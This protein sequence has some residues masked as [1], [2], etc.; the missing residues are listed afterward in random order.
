MDSV[1]GRGSAQRSTTPLQAC[2]GQHL[3]AAPKS[4]VHRS[5]RIAAGMPNYDRLPLGHLLKLWD[6]AAPMQRPRLAGGLSFPTTE[7]VQ[8]RRNDAVGE[9]TLR[10]ESPGLETP[11]LQGEER[12]LQPN[13]KSPQAPGATPM[14]ATTNGQTV[15]R[16]PGSVRDRSRASGAGRPGGRKREL[17]K[18]GSQPSAKA[19]VP[20]R[21]NQGHGSKWSFPKVADD[22][23]AKTSSLKAKLTTS[24][25]AA[26]QGGETCCTRGRRE[27]HGELP[28]AQAGRHTELPWYLPA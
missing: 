3:A 13:R 16:E 6:K 9:E 18:R 10:G 28:R 4:G 2:D 15:R 22:P 7:S 21:K 1:C 14:R 27:N 20:E 25:T 8:A 26:S 5:G 17:W 12:S 19:I 24:I 23:R 11:R